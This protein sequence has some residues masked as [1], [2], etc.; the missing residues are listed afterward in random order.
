MIH[1][2]TEVPKQDGKGEA[3]KGVQMHICIKTQDFP[4]DLEKFNKLYKIAIAIAN[5]LVIFQA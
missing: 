5:Q 2:S 1:F 3:I 4:K